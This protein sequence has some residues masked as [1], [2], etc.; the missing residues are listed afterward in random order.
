LINLTDLPVTSPS[1]NVLLS[2]AENP[3][4]S[5]KIARFE[6]GVVLVM[7]PTPDAVIAYDEAAP[8]SAELAFIA[9]RKARSR[10]ADRANFIPAILSNHRIPP[11]IEIIALRII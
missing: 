9:P 11:K 1:E 4:K 10:I 2:C 6:T 3:G 8:G 7:G 5:F